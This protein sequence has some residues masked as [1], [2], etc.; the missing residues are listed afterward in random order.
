[1]RHIL[2][3]LV[4]VVLLFPS[5]ALGETV[6]FENLIVREGLH[7]KTFTDVP[8]TDEFVPIGIGVS[9]KAIRPSGL[10]VGAWTLRQ[11]KTFSRTS[12]K[13]GNG[14]QNGYDQMSHRGIVTGNVG[15]GE[16]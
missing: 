13:N 9:A 2:T 16:V 10:V 8:F 5:L 6:K 1:M 3:S 14:H 7:Y 11:G 12:Q 4:L 15:D